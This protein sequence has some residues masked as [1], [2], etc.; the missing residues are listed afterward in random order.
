MQPAAPKTL[1]PIV[2][3]SMHKVVTSH[4]LNLTFVISPELEVEPN[5]QQ[6]TGLMLLVCIQYSFNDSMKSRN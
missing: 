6:N 4:A 1:K 5:Q 3:P 2:P